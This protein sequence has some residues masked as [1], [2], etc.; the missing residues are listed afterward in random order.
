M[1][2]SAFTKLPALCAALLLAA[3]GAPASE[4]PASSATA[5]DASPPQAV[6]MSRGTS[7]SHFKGSSRRS[8][9]IFRARSTAGSTSLGETALNSKTVLRDSRAV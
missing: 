7:S 1:K 6:A 4:R 3:C 9:S 5:E 2:K 8:C